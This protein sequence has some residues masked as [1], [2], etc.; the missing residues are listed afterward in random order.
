MA[1]I[2]L[3]GKLAISQVGKGMYGI[4]TETTTKNTHTFVTDDPNDLMDILSKIFRGEF[5]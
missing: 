5:K 1:A 4:E 2:D 3:E